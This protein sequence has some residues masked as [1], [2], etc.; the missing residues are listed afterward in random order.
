MVPTLAK[1]QNGDVFQLAAPGVVAIAED[2]DATI[3]ASTSFAVATGATFIEISAITKGIFLKWGGTAISTD[4][5]V[6]IGADT[7]RV[8]VIPEGQATF[9]VIEQSAT[10]IVAVVQK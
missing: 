1:D 9:E 7:T 3:S 8:L 5:D 2:Y 10:A 6:Y 4:F